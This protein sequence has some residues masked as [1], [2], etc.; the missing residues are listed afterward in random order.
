MIDILCPNC[1]KDYLEFHPQHQRV[2]GCASCMKIF[3]YPSLTPVE[4]IPT[5]EPETR[6]AIR[7]VTMSKTIRFME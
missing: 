4:T 3:R 5:D 7:A 2:C 6:P 1:K